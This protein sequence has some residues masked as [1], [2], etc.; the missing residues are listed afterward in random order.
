MDCRHF[1]SGLYQSDFE[2]DACGIGMI[3]ASDGRL[4]HAL[5]EK[6]VEIL[7]NLAHRGAQGADGR[8]S[9]GAGILTQIPKRLFEREP[10]LGAKLKARSYSVGVLFV[11]R[12]ESARAK[13]EGEFQR[14]AQEQG[15]TALAWRTVPVK[16]DLLGA[17]ARAMEPLIRQVFLGDDFLE[18]ERERRL[19]LVRKRAE[20]EL[21]AF[22]G[23][24][25]PD[26]GEVLTQ[27]YVVSLSSRTMVLKGLMLPE[28]LADYFLD[29]QNP[30]FES[31]IAMV[32][33]RFSTNTLP[34]WELAHPYR[35][36]CHNGEINTLRGNLNWMKARGS[37]L[38]ELRPLI[39][40][41]L[42]DSGS[43]DHAVELLVRSGRQLPE[44][45]MM[46]QP[47]P[48]EQDPAMPADVRAFYEFNAARMEPWDG[49][50]A[51]CFTDGRV[52]G[53]SLDRN[54]L[55]PCRY[56]ILDNGWVV[57]SSEAGALPIPNSQIIK[58]ARLGPGRMLVIDTVKGKIFEDAEV[59]RAIAG[60]RPYAEWL[61]EERLAFRPKAS[62]AELP[63]LQS[64]PESRSAKVRAAGYTDEEVRMVL[65]P[66]LSG[67]EEATSSM[68]NDTPL[69]VLSERPQLLFKYFRQL[70]AQVTNP[71]IDPIRE[72]PVMSLSMYLGSRPNPFMVG[73]DG[74]KRVHSD[75]P[76]LDRGG[77]ATLLGLSGRPGQRFNVRTLSTLFRA[78]SGAQG[79][80]HALD[81]LCAEAL[82]A[83]RDGV[84]VLILSDRDSSAE[85]A[86]MPSLLAAAA[87]HHALIREGLRTRLSLVLDSAEPRDVHHFACLIGYGADAVHP[88]LV[89]DVIDQLAADG[90]LPEAVNT[91]K[92][93]ANFCKAI[94]KGLLKIMSKMGISTLQSY[95]GAQ[96]FEALG[97]SRH[98]VDLHFHGTP[99]RIGGLGLDEI[100]EETLRRHRDAF[101]ETRLPSG[102]DIHYRHGEEAHLWN[103]M[104]IAKL[105]IATR[106]RDAATFAEF[107]AE[108]ERTSKGTLRGL[109]GFHAAGPRLPIEQVESASSIVKRF[110]TGA[111]SFGALGK[112]A[113]ETLALAMNRIGAK[114]NS[115]EGGEDAARFSSSSTD[116]SRNS[117]IKQVASGRFGVTAHYLVNA[118]ELQIKMAQGA[119]PGEGGQLPGHKVDETIARLRHST[120]GV[121]LISPPP[122]HDIYSIEDLAQLIFDLKR[123][124]PDA[125]VSVKLVSAPGVGTVAAGVAKAHAD[126]I[127]ISGDGGGTGASPLSS[128]KYAGSPWEL[129]L[130]ETQQTLV[131]QGLRGRVRLEA[132]GQLRNG[133]DVVV[134]AL[135]GAE[136]FGF[137]TAPLIVEGCIMMRKCH[138]NTCPVGVATQDPILRAKFKG[139]PEHVIN[140]F[141]FV[142][143]EVRQL[144]AEL[145]IAK[146]EELV[147]RAD[148]L[149]AL[150]PQKMWKA[151][152]LDLSKLLHR[153]E[154]RIPGIITERHYS[155]PAPAWPLED[156]DRRLLEAC[157]PAI[158]KGARVVRHRLHVRNTDRAVGTLLSSQVAR[159]LGAQGLPADTIDLRFNGSAGQSFGAF[160]ANG[161]TLRLEGE[162]NDYV[163]KGLSGG[164]IVIAP[165]VRAS[166]ARMKET[167]LDVIAGNTC[168]YGA[169]SGEVFIAGAVGERFAVRNS[170]ATAVVEGVGDHGC[171]YMTGGCV[172]VLGLTGRN[173][174]A[175]MSGGVAYVL[176]VDGH[177][178][179]R[180]PVGSHLEVESV[181]EVDSE[182][183]LKLIRRHAVETASSRAARLLD[184][185]SQSVRRFFRVMPIEYKRALANRM[186]PKSTTGPA[187]QTKNIQDDLHA[188]DRR[189]E[190][191]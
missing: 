141:F 64:T 123:I 80:C 31:A 40:D 5:V 133:R 190:V 4:S 16:S 70:F 115:G 163:G 113:H 17:Q 58:R 73:P 118:Q 112:E 186:S 21:R 74:K 18:D 153:P 156:L 19:L 81:H 27:F 8:T 46:L 151:H 90:R 102:G 147:G 30:N 180:C 175:G 189:V 94:D 140:Y 24:R 119:K 93:N 87:T 162:S 72:R 83:A 155:K 14:F 131:M 41:G 176:D 61:S 139:Q 38:P 168:L 143:E 67:G 104:S 57:L 66:M 75:Q 103:P 63:E 7:A 76:V 110:T 33:S 97:I 130:A 142:A 89:F 82:K 132:D 126:K 166:S 150:P 54:G 25:H 26:T 35:F 37:H 107:S 53:A 134:A 159:A 36:I 185:W 69:A 2:K 187:Q 62:N 9:D 188:D 50:A 121:T 172:V 15:F 52:I 109:L 138:L 129:G 105:Q 91:K 99:S 45:I 169:T 92:A 86:M 122:H 68:G 65:M 148:L 12:E 136:E 177:F 77:F 114:S 10:E 47:E 79:M 174:A 127:L 95:C 98:V 56:F 179:S 149:E 84:E 51:L 191:I 182:M 85:F 124:N 160:L 158:S 88:Y 165:A 111:M 71:P 96:I 43:L 22:S 117:A 164:R 13:C 128:I 42:S 60:E 78:E 11:P 135:L 1:E 167:D 39:P 125:R 29:L 157:E 28:H 181:S 152:T 59:K 100:A 146:F 34:S 23:C 44:A 171:E 183:L 20:R 170:G 116:N 161:I 144:M 32:H 108:V 48:W 49:P 173:F 154:C 120:P 184:N 145:G 55:R 6:S 3:A 106:E 137:S 101:A 178:H